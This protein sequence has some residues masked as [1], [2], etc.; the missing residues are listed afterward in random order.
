MLRD[1]ALGATTRSARRTP[2]HQETIL[3]VTARSDFA[4]RQLIESQS[5]QRHERRPGKVP[6]WRKTRLSLLPPTAVFV[7]IVPTRNQATAC[8]EVK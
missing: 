5:F 2:D 7:R 4:R 1:D 6:D 3:T 8:G